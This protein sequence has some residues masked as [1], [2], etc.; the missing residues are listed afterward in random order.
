MR[1]SVNGRPVDLAVRAE[2]TALD[3][4]RGPLGLTGTKLACG[5]GTCGA[6]TVLA[7][8]V[9]VCACLLPAA[10]LD[11]RRITTIEAFAA[12]DHP[13]Q[14]AFMH[15]DALQC[16]YC[17]PG[18]VV[19]SIAFFDAWRASEGRRTPPPE[20][21]AEA[22][23]GHLCRCGAYPNIRR[24]IARACAGDYDEAPAAPPPRHDAAAKVTGAAVYTVD[25]RLPGQLEGRILRAPLAHAEI[26]RLDVSPA[27]ASA[28]VVAAVDLTGGLTSVRYVGQELA[29]VAA[30]DRE[31]AREALACIE[32]SFR[33]LPPAIGLDA[34]ARDAPRVYPSIFSH[35]VSESELPLV[36]TLWHGNLRGPTLLM[37]H[38][39]V[40][41]EL[42][43]HEAER[44]GGED[45]VKGRWRSSSQSH[46][47]LE[48]HAC[49]AHWTGE[50]EVEVYVST[51]ACADLAIDIAER[52]GLRRDH[53]RVRC[54]F[55]GGAFGAKADLT[56][57]TVAAIELSRAARR[58]VRVV[59]GN[60]EELVAG[61]YRPGVAMD[62]SLHMQAGGAID[63]IG[64]TA[65]SDGGV[66][67]GS[68]VASVAR[69]AYPAAPKWLADYD[70]VSHAPPGKPFRGPGGPAAF[71]ALEQAV[72]IAVRRHGLDAV[73]VRRAND[74][75]PGTSALLDWVESIPAWTD[76]RQSPRGDRILRGVGLATGVWTAFVH[77]DTSVTVSAGPDGLV[78]SCACQDMGNG[79]RTVLA[80]AVGD[81][82]GVEPAAVDVR[83]GD[84]RLVRATMSSGSRTTASVA[85][86]AES[87]AREVRDRVGR[88]AALRLGMDRP[89]IDRAGVGD[90]TSVEPWPT[91]LAGA[92]PVEVTMKRP[93]DPG[94][95]VL[96][97]ALDGFLVG[98]ARPVSAHVCEVE[99]DRRTG[100]VRV[101]RIWTGL[102]VGR[103]RVEPLAR[104]Q[105]IGG[106]VQGV[107]Y[108]LYEE[109]RLDPVTGRTLT[110][111]LDDHR[112]CG[113]A[114]APEVNV[115]FVS[116]DFESMAGGGVGLGELTTLAVAASIGNAVFDATGWRPTELPLRI[117]RVLPA[118][119]A[120]GI[121]ER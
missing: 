77:S 96:P 89:T 31:R 73:A 83:L 56:M 50:D 45:L 91:I 32:V 111:S 1:C 54:A 10:D 20:A 94:G 66:A 6:C 19:Q 81:V 17:T 29:A 78:V 104:S 61:G 57:E 3:V 69:F 71:W 102:S 51:Q 12:A 105:A 74:P 7:D 18:F 110:Q 16:G 33:R 59:L 116:G 100:R 2:D 75:D 47:P 80:R 114:D 108:A 65:R 27:A 64:L 112:L 88:A 37:S 52:W 39:A 21:I 98:R 87:A 106:A 97:I 15:E 14:R 13:V 79:T 107:S 46:T 34:A 41:A 58:P 86:A 120:L 72:D 28:G 42:R 25:V 22:C 38:H 44:A 85:P 95:H 115:H 63:A 84:S 30:D 9:P 70:V 36:P 62:L 43:L 93:R 119:R 121:D 23:A 48:P 8:E 99:V 24:A 117:E 90:G 113:L 53:V 92:D 109:R 103:I 76:R 55:I 35:K 101:P 11:G 40:R 49:V 4:L 60:D 118:L 5:A 82:F 67:I 68:T 26:A